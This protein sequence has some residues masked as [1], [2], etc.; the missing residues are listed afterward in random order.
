MMEAYSAANRILLAAANFAV[1]WAYQPYTLSYNFSFGD[2][3]IPPINWHDTRCQELVR[4]V[5]QDSGGYV[6]Q[7]YQGTWQFVNVF[8]IWSFSQNGDRVI[9]GIT[10]SAKTVMLSTDNKDVSGLALAHEIGHALI[11][12]G[13]VLEQGNLMHEDLDK[14]GANLNQEQVET[15]TRSY[16]QRSGGS[17]GLGWGA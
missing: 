6:K 10:P 7:F 11:G 3:I 17:A 8:F 9:R 16:G 4:M 15:I 12:P 2:P 13:H 5:L 1:P 14:A